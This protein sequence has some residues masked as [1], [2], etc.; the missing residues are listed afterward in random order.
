MYSGHV[1]EQ[2]PYSP[3]GSLKSTTRIGA[4]FL[5]S[6]HDHKELLH[7]QPHQTTKQ[8]IQ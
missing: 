1:E 3:S 2:G 4:T 8:S 6:P 7:Y 5:S